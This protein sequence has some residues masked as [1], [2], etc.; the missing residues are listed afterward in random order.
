[1]R[2]GEYSMEELLPIVAE[3]ARKYTSN[4][5]TSV[6]Y[7]V[8]RGLMQSVIYCIEEVYH[9]MDENRIGYRDES[10]LS[11]NT[12]DE[13]YGML[14]NFAVRLPNS[15]NGI[16][17]A[18]EAFQ[19]GL[20]YIK[21]KIETSR[22]QFDSIA[23]GFYS[24]SNYC[25]Y[26]TIIKGMP[27]FFE[28]YNPL[29]ASYD[30]ILTL[31]YPLLVPIEGMCGIDLIHEYLQRVY[32]EQVFLNIFP[33]E[34]VVSLLS[35]YNNDYEELII[36]LCEPV[37]QYAIACQVVGRDIKSLELDEE[38][39]NE[40]KRCLLR[41]KSY[42]ELEYA[43]TKE[44]KDLVEKFFQGDILL[45]SYLRSSLPD[46]VAVLESCDGNDRLRRI[47]PPV[48]AE[49]NMDTIHYEMGTQ[50]SDE[51]LR[52][53]IESIEECQFIS[54]KLVLIRENVTNLDDYKEILNE[55]F[56]EADYKEVFALLTE[57]EHEVLRNE[58]KEK[59]DFDQELV[60]WE[61]YLYRN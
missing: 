45:S 16:A 37:L 49:M 40:F 10:V 12:S 4:E 61:V 33:R 28:R 20:E 6:T 32:L 60:E 21:L 51:D 54:E 18:K 17:S 57:Q 1:M 8:A 11:D 52:L 14:Q 42:E 19:K 41:S 47:L 27:A 38:D 24:F 59:L 55:C 36:N 53:L 9:T 31:D 3:L 7:V 5:S 23:S 26:D 46:Y 48:I 43:L 58:I 50:M 25:Y 44:V 30:H 22:K 15:V 39:I 13:R 56:Y 29:F 2:K 34:K 35:R